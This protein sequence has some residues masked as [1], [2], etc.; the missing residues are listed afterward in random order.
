MRGIRALR[1]RN[2]VTHLDSAGCGSVAS[3]ELGSTCGIRSRKIQCP[4]DVGQVFRKADARFNPCCAYAV[5]FPQLA[6]ARAG[7]GVELCRK[8]QC[9]I[10]INQITRR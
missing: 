2:D 8:E 7:W 5:A 10:D 4:I 1:A 9:S 3:P 6:D